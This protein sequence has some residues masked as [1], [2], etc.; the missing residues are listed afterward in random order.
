LGDIIEVQG[1]SDIVSTA[2]VTEYIHSQDAAGEKAYP[3]VT[4][5]N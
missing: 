2:R 5:I 4:M 3:T 1:N